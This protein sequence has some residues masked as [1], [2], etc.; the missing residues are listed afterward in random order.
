[1]KLKR[2]NKICHIGCSKMFQ[3]SKHEARSY[4]R[5]PKIMCQIYKLRR[6]PS[7]PSLFL[8]RDQDCVDRYCDWNNFTPPRN[9]SYG[10]VLEIIKVFYNRVVGDDAQSQYMNKEFVMLARVQFLETQ[11]SQMNETSGLSYVKLPYADSNSSSSNSIYNFEHSPK[12][13]FTFLS[14][15]VDQI[16]LVSDI[17]A[18]F[19][20]IAANKNVF[21]TLY[22]SDSACR[23]MKQ[24]LFQ[25]IE[26]NDV[27]SLY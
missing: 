6:V 7:V 18:E 22:N 4:F 1:M 13:Y 15:I 10:K 14:H 23:S 25:V 9:F 3:K 12:V 11:G 8:N 27:N 19:N 16:Y 21:G 2:N 20:T 24:T 17:R 26:G 5:I